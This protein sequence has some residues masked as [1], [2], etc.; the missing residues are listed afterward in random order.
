MRRGSTRKAQKSELKRSLVG[1]IYSLSRAADASHHTDEGTFWAV[2]ICAFKF[3]LQWL[4]KTKQPLYTALLPPLSRHKLALVNA[5]QV[6]RHFGSETESAVTEGKQKDNKE[7]KNA[8]RLDCWSAGCEGDITGRGE[9]TS[10]YER[11]SGRQEGCD[12]G[13]RKHKPSSHRTAAPPC[14]KAVI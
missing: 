9:T 3:R 11:R 1:Q 10:L 4:N 6:S 7:Q 5:R 8:D 12:E 2:I 13:E 14:N